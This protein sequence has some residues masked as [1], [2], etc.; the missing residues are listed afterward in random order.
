MRWA[1]TRVLPLPGPARI[2]IGP[3]SVSTARRCAGFSAARIS[4][5]GV[6]ILPSGWRQSAAILAERS[7]GP[8][9]PMS[10]DTITDNWQ[11]LVAVGVGYA[12]L[13]WLAMAVW[14]LRDIRD[15]T[16]DPVAQVLSV[17]LVLVFNFPGLLIYLIVRPRETL[18]EVYERSLE[19]EALLQELEDQRAC[20][21]CKRRVQE[22]FIVCP[23]CEFQLKESCANCEKPLSHNWAACPY[24]GRSRRAGAGERRPRAARSSAAPV[25]PATTAPLVEMQR[26]AH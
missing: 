21:S 8:E 12:L 17:L 26:E 3:S 6:A 9:Q 7:T 14:A 1:I 18:A 15:R 2:S 19:E 13:I 16:R 23:Y 20:P 5:G 25:S 24:C 10:L 11:R 4:M 22:E